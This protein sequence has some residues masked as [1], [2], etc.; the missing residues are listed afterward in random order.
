MKIQKKI[1]NIHQNFG[2]V[3]VLEPGGDNSWQD[4]N[5][6]LSDYPY[7]KDGFVDLDRGKLLVSSGK[8]KEALDRLSAK[9]YKL[10]LKNELEKALKV[11]KRLVKRIREFG[12]SAKTMI[13]TNSDNIKNLSGFEAL[14]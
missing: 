5:D 14:V 8:E 6:M 2:D 7:R 1:T 9:F 4:L 13:V 10:C 12:R 11:S 3:V